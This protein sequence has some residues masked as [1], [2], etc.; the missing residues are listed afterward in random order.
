MPVTPPEPVPPRPAVAG[1]LRTAD[2]RIL[3]ARR[4]P[5]LRFMGGHYAFPGGSVDADDNLGREP[6]IER[7][8]R[9]DT[10]ALARE[11]FEE[12]GLL[13]ASG[14]LPS[15]TERRAARLAI[16]AGELRFRDFLSQAG[17]QIDQQRFRPSGLFVTPE[18]SRR[19]YH[20]RYYLI[21]DVTAGEEELI[22]GEVVALRWLLPAEARRR[23]RKK[24]IEIAPPVAAVLRQ[25]ADFSVAAALTRLQDLEPMTS[26]HAHCHE[27]RIGIHVMPLRT[28]TLP[29]ARHTNCVIVGEEKIFIVDPGT[30]DEGEQRRL[31]HRIDY[32]VEHE[33]AEPAAVLLT[34][35]LSDHVG[36]A[37]LV[38]DR[39]RIPIWAHE[40][41][42]RQLKF[43]VDRLLVDNDS[44]D[45]CGD[46]GWSLRCLH[47]PGHHPGHLC[48]LEE[49]S[50][51]LICGDMVAGRSSIIIAHSH[52]GD[53]SAYLASMQRLLEMD[54]DLMI[55][56]HGFSFPKPHKIIQ[57]QIDHRLFRERRVQAA[58][59]KGLKTID[60]LLAEV[61]DDVPR[62]MWKYAADTL[63]AHLVRLGHTDF[64]Q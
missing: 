1:V 61:Y 56:A 37:T 19:R 22:T 16:L 36:A 20:A 59:D 17:L 38:R 7:D 58:L 15:P 64:E 39:Y 60:Q 3:L 18:T 57:K 11:L 48:F 10:M 31:T 42:A 52:G 32:F 40:V 14:E 35:G 12:T 6:T 47:T 49:T 5:E 50:G 45:I 33:H 9:A 13:F 46:P 26:D 30:T 8:A 34:H 54:F 25:F 63:K 29:P 53:M 55:P 24:E 2:G 4:N 28:P 62:A 21:E 27:A 23:W 44:I 41:T 43:P 51:T